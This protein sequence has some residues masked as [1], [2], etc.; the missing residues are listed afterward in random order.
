MT[1]KNRYIRRAKISEAKFRQLLKYF[2][3]DLD[4]QTIASLSGLNRNT[5]NR[6]L[7]LIRKRIADFCEKQSPFKEDTGID[8]SYF[9]KKHIKKKPGRV[10]A[11]N[12]PIFGIRKRGNKIYTE[13]IPDS[14]KANLPAI[15]RGHIGPDDGVR[16]EECC[17]YNGLVDMGLKKYSRVNH[18]K[19][20]VKKGKN[21]L[22]GAET[23][24]AN[25]KRRLEK[26]HGISNST[27]Y[28]HLKESEFRFNHRNEDIYKLLLKMF[29]ENPLC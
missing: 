5:V 15:I 23:F 21:R 22:N 7:N 26:F 14:S 12:M 19:A 3:L 17:R 24:W 2:S 20:E 16:L 8:E 25:T 10:T 27:F 6:Y 28:L 13:I 4:A 9:H 18:G 29:R 1:V 11:R